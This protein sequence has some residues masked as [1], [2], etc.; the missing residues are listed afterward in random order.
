MKIPSKSLLRSG[1][2]RLLASDWWLA[3]MNQR[4]RS[5]ASVP[6]DESCKSDPSKQ[7][8]NE[9]KNPDGASDPKAYVRYLDGIFEGMSSSGP[10]V[11]YKCTVYERMDIRAGD[12]IADI[13]CGT[14][15]D[16]LALAELLSAETKKTTDGVW[17]KILGVDISDTMVREARDKVSKSRWETSEKKVEISFHTGNAQK[18]GDRI[19]SN[20]FDICRSDRSLQHMPDPQAA[21]EEMVRISKPGIGR[22]VISEPD[23]E[24]LV[25]DSPSHTRVTRKIVN[26]FTDTRVNGWM[27]RQLSRIMKTAG[28]VDVTILPMTCPVTELGFVR[29][30]YLDKARKIAVEASVVTDQEA[31]DW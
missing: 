29:G 6:V 20:S 30:A 4:A 5:I 18:L 14:G 15:A 28:L 1:K 8:E 12:S 25:L 2:D 27:G 3:S 26:H 16:V 10:V 11:D 13:G 21:V 17:G 23:W 7:E 9:W 24:T 19:P 22:I 31:S